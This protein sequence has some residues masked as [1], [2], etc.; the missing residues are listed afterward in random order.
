MYLD[1]WGL[2][3]S[4]FENV[5][6]DRFF[7]SPQHE[8]ALSRMLYAG[9]QRK[10]AAMLTGEVGTGKTTVAKAFTNQLPPTKYDVQILHNPAL[11]P[12]D[13]LK[14]VLIQFGE[15]T[16]TDS[17]TILLNQLQNRLSRNAAEGRN[18]ILVVDEAHVIDDPATLEELRMM[19]NFHL[20]GQFLITIV[21]LGLPPLVAK[22]ADLQPLKER[23][24][25]KYHLDPL[26]LNNTIRYILFRIKHAGATRGSFSKAAILKLH[27]Y[28]EGLPLRINNI[29][30][31]CLLIGLMRRAR[32]ID[33]KI[34]NEAIEDIK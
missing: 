16:D 28:S 30:D 31:R 9:R 10:G 17:K 33:T 23:I 34:V 2:K 32:I 22:I 27:E 26:D 5:P 7:P 24:G 12:T 4:P 11:C 25:V 3:E 14:A 13:L 29:C 8:E 15:K 18:S 1:Y 6:S 19:L 21:L 20:D